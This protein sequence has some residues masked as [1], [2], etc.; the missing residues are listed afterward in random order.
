M[1][2]GSDFCGMSQAQVKR[3]YVTEISSRTD[4]IGLNAE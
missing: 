1:L 2:Y 3:T 4:E